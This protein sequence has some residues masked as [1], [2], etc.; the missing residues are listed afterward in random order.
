MFLKTHIWIDD[1]Y[2]KYLCIF[3]FYILISTILDSMLE[4][5]IIIKN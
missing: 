3:A 2:I 5:D 4:N 1:N